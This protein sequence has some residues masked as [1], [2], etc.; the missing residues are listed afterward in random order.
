MRKNVAL[1]MAVVACA[2]ILGVGTAFAGGGH[3]CGGK[4][5]DHAR[6]AKM[7]CNMTAEQCAEEMQKTLSTRGWLGISFDDD[8]DV[9]TINKVYS[10]SPAERAGFQEGDRIVSINGV[11]ADEKHEEKIHGMLKTA[12]IGDQV[13]YVVT[14]GSQNLTLNAT[15]AQMPQSL[16]AEAIE[17]HK[18]EEH[19]MAKN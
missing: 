10:G 2:V 6:H 15:L 12:K 14:R 5:E 8:E 9:V 7:E 16:I 13:A 4:S 17:H 11:P 18:Q 19:S 1:G 3:D